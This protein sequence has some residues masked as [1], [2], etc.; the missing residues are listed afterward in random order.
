MMAT[1]TMAFGVLL[2]AVSLW[3][4]L[5]AAEQARS[6]TAFI[7]GGVGIV[8]LLLGALAYKESLRKH[9]MHAAAGIGLLGFLGAAARLAMVLAKGEKGVFERGPLAMLLM[10]ILCAA[11]EAL[12]V[13]SFIQA[14]RARK[15]GEAPS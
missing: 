7:P 11:F 8:L 2:V 3:G 10:A 1:L 9:V 13:N 12:C 4:Y 14:R 15:S 5:G 6:A